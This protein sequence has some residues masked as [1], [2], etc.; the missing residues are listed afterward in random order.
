MPRPHLPSVARLQVLG[1]SRRARWRRW[2]LRRAVAAACTVAA[3]L[4]LVGVVRPPPP[5][6]TPVLVAARAL[7]S[8]AVLDHADLRLVRVPRDPPPVATTSDPGSLVGR[9]LGV[10]VLGGEP[11]TA[12]RLVPRTPGEGLPPRT[13]AAHV[14]VA[15]ER[16]LDLVFAGHRVTLFAE[17]GGAAL[18]RDVLV[19]SVDTPGP[20]SVTGPLSGADGAPRGLVCALTDE[21]LERV[22]AGQRPEGGPPRVLAVVTRD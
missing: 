19:L 20:D 6:T 18:A 4:V 9:R 1:P 10:G 13:V 14:V 15:D 12:T 2:A 17:I 3:V 16:L 5:P 22:F 7:S 8:G 21:D 11:V